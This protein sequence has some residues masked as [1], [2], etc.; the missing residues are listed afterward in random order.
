VREKKER[1][2]ERN[3]GGREG[4]FVRRRKKQKQAESPRRKSTL[5]CSPPSSP[6][7]PLGEEAVG[8]FSNAERLP[9]ATLACPV[10]Q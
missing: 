2:R 3:N 10:A 9:A 5:D 7:L 4:V 8:Q 1:E 6:A